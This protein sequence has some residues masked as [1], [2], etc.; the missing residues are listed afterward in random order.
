MDL[1]EAI[2]M[3]RSVRAYADRPVEQ[4]KLTR[5]LDAARLAPSGNNRQMWKFIVVR[6]PA[7][8]A[9]LANAAEQAF[10]GKAPVLIATV[11][12]DA[13]RVMFCG[14]PSGPVD[15]AIAQEHMALAAVAESLGT[16]WIGRF[17][18]DAC[19]KIL[20]VPPT[21]RIIEMLAMGYPADAPKERVRKALTEIVSYDKF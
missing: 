11:S 15:C 5:I 4:S 17:D 16:C 13:D 12:L 18:Q 1:Y 3:R 21:A 10:I 6:D 8:R 2:Q 7:V 14:V 9:A 19:R 20:S